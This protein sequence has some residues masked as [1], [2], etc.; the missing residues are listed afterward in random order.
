M[1]QLPSPI[2]NYY[3]HVYTNMLFGEIIFRYITR[4]F[5]KCSLKGHSYTE[6]WPFFPLIKYL[7]IDF[8]IQLYVVFCTK[9]NHQVEVGMYTFLIFNF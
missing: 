9:Y 7:I 1:H 3:L 2:N 4:F 8:T 5:R 6:T